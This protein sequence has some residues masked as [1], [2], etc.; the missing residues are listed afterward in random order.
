MLLATDNPKR[1]WNAMR[2]RLTPEP[3]LLL[4]SQET[5]LQLFSRRALRS[6]A[7]NEYEPQGRH[8]NHREARIGRRISMYAAICVAWRFVEY[9]SP[10]R[11]MLSTPS[12]RVSSSLILWDVS[13]YVELTRH[14]QG[15]IEVRGIW[16]LF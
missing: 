13:L 10:G 11:T 1:C 6:R 2:G 16:R 15:W 3:V 8:P 5:L 14:K 9:G 7:D 12:R 4:C